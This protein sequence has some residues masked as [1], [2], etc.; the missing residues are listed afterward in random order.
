MSE[1]GSAP[2]SGGT[3]G[4]IGASGDAGR[5]ADAGAGA[6]GEVS[7]PQGGDGGGGGAGGSSPGEGG[8]GG[9]GAVVV[10]PATIRWD[11]EKSLQGWSGVG[12]PIP[13]DCLD[14]ITVSS[15]AAHS[16]DA[17]LTMTFDGLYT[18]D[19]GS[20]NPYYGVISSSA[21]PP[22]SKVTTWMRSTAPG[23]T[24]EW[25]VQLAPLYDWVQLTHPSSPVGVDMWTA[26]TFT[27]PPE[28]VL[29]FGVKVYTPLDMTGAIY[30]D[31][32]SW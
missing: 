17:S 14:S 31:H 5:S 32:V 19:P 18:P 13:A 16:G 23:V 9:G 20:R 24:A 6:G 22:G 11:F 2:I 7:L 21:P 1:G 25:F 28:A 30:L 15:D 3:S 27:M 8:D 12:E 26:Y 4:H 10:P 29:G